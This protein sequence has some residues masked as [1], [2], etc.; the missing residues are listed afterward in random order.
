MLAPW[1]DSELADGAPVT[2]SKAHEARAEQLV[3]RRVRCAVAGSLEGLLDRART[4][5]RSAPAATIAPCWEQVLGAAPLIASTVSHL[6][7]GEPVDAQ[8]I[9]RLKLLV[10]DRRG[11][12]YRRSRPDALAA[13]LLEISQLH[14]RE[15][16]F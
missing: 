7:S 10:S 15:R 2:L 3:G 6:R 11:P 4:P 12:C 1:L 14:Q 16:V 13:A 8:A 5:G 9:A